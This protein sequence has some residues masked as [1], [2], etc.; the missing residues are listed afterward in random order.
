MV[1]R[2][3]V[4]R[5]WRRTESVTTSA[6]LFLSCRGQAIA[7]LLEVVWSCGNLR[8][9]SGGAPKVS[10]LPPSRQPLWRTGPLHFRRGQPL[11]RIGMGYAQ[12]AITFDYEPSQPLY[13]YEKSMFSNPTS[14]SNHCVGAGYGFHNINHCGG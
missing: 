2:E 8:G 7:V 11:G 9:G 3:L 4:R 6:T 1:L 12:V 10:P 14:V 5:L 13:D